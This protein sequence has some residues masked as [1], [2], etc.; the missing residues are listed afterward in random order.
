MTL[1]DQ[2]QNELLIL[3]E[4]L[5]QMIGCSP[6][7][8]QKLKTIQ[9][10]SKLPDLYEEFLSKLGHGAGTLFRGTSFFYAAMTYFNFKLEAVDFLRE[11]NLAFKLPEDAFVF[12]WHQAYTFMYFNT[13]AKESD[14]TIY[15]YIEGDLIPKTVGVFSHLLLEEL[16]LHKRTTRG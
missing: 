4:P 11:K 6:V 12:L 9:G 15:R 5:E 16:E 14:P 1:I 3:G 13:E 10:V 2:L 7:E 8:I